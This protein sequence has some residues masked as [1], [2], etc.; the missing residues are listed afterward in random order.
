MA[1]MNMKLIRKWMYVLKARFKGAWQHRGM[2][3]A[4]ITSIA[5]VLIILGVVLIA[6]LG[7]NQVLGD[8]RY[9]V[10]DIEIF[11][12]VQCPQS[13]LSDMQQILQSDYR[14]KEVYFKSSKEAMESM[15]EDLGDK[16]SLL[17]SVGDDILPASFIVKLNDIDEAESFVAEYSQKQGVNTIGY[18][19]DLIDKITQLANYGKIAALVVIIGLLLLYSLLFRTL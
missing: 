19:K 9:K 3:F 6:A 16:A 12:N 1:G 17:D 4:S 7:L 18:Y 10:D 5:A 14:V 15:R 13:Q 2:G 8:L 11:M